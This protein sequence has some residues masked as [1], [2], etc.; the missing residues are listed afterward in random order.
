MVIVKAEDA[1]P[2]KVVGATLSGAKT[3]GF[4]SVIFA[5]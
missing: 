1:T 3:A 2:Y 4:V 5:R